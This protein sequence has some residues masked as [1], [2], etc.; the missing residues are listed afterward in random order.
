[1]SND[2]KILV[3][4][5]LRNLPESPFDQFNE[6]F[7]LYRKAS[8]KNRATESTYNRK[9]YSE[10]GLKNL[11]YDLKKAY[12]ISDIEV[13]TST[14][15]K[16]QEVL[17]DTNTIAEAF[18][19]IEETSKKAIYEAAT[20]IIKFSD[21]IEQYDD[22]KEKVA[23]GTAIFESF[24][25][26]NTELIIS[27]NQDFKITDVLESKIQEDPLFMESFGNYG[28]E[29]PEET[30][31]ETTGKVLKLD[32]VVGAETETSLRAEFPFLNNPDCPQILYIVVGKRIAS[33]NKH[34]E[35][36]AKLQEINEGKL[37]ATPEELKDITA[38]CD[39]AFSDNRALWDELN[40][41]ATTG[42]ILGK[43]PI[44]REDNIKKEV[45]IMSNDEMFKFI[46]NSSKYFHDQKAALEKHKDNTVKLSE[47]ETRIA[48]RKYKLLLVEAKAGVN[49]GEKK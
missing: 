48:D 6:A 29:V 43:H 23:I 37:E 10:Q 16:F 42:E 32:T 11:L 12:E 5:F 7:A 20:I 36:H 41:Y 19:K 39:F 15:D 18:E 44:F 8:S 38:E 34:K 9:G 22:L 49:A 2:L 14:E 26:Q 1:M 27:E 24:K 31:D 3:L 35:L 28:F 46:K 40:H 25:N 17:T 13:L 4:G 47:I 45:D 30:T 33:Y 21:F